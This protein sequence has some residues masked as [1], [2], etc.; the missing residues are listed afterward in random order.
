MKFFVVKLSLFLNNHFY[1]FKYNRGEHHRGKKI[2]NVIDRPSCIS[3]DVTLSDD[4]TTAALHGAYRARNL[5]VSALLVYP[6]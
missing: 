5:G 6:V 1:V 2:G 3:Y 4:W